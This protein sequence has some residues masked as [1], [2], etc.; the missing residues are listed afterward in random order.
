MEKW[1]FH[2]CSMTLDF[3][4]RMHEMYGNHDYT[5]E[6]ERSFPYFISKNLGID[7]VN[8]A[9]GGNS[10]ETIIRESI[11]YIIM[12]NV[13]G[14]FIGLSGWD[15]FQ[16]EGLQRN[17]NHVNYKILADALDKG[18][19]SKTQ[20]DKLLKDDPF[21]L[22]TIDEIRNVSTSQ[23]KW[24]LKF[25]YDNAETTVFT[26]ERIVND[27]RYRE[28]FATRT[29]K[30]LKILSEL[31][32]KNKIPLV[33]CQMIR[34]FADMDYLNDVTEYVTSKKV[35]K[36][37]HLEN[38]VFKSE[39]FNEF[40]SKIKHEDHIQLIYWPFIE[41][42]GGTSMKEES[43]VMFGNYGSLF[44]DPDLD[45]HWKIDG[46]KAVAAYFHRFIERSIRWKSQN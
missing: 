14:V 8:L 21:A 32:K 27:K 9:D 17:V 2:G 25:S 35:Y 20:L 33:V 7:F 16:F 31:C 6:E 41:K 24:N 1:L 13:D 12:N 22:T 38:I 15:R 37:K 3:Y 4:G 5:E 39:I 29:L 40:D 11:D 28:H 26:N 45:H 36:A 23:T 19:G 42:F 18:I 34:P 46:H 10:N 44:F 43:S 30:L